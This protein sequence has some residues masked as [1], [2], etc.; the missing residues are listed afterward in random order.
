MEAYIQDVDEILDKLL[1]LEPNK[2]QIIEDFNQVIPEF[3]T[4][5]RKKRNKLSQASKIK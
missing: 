2:E 3:V 4:E 1:Q 5:E